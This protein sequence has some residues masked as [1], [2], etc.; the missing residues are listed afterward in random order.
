MPNQL[1]LCQSGDLAVDWSRSQVLS[2]SLQVL[3]RKFTTPVRLD[4]SRGQDIH[5]GI[6]TESNKRY[7]HFKALAS[8]VSGAY[9]VVCNIEEL[10]ECTDVLKPTTKENLKFHVGVLTGS[11]DE[12]SRHRLSGSVIDGALVAPFNAFSSSANT[13][14][15]KH[16]SDNLSTSTNVDIANFTY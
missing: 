11:V 6:N 7:A 16:I 14:V 13:G 3:N 8:R 2:A 15:V 4:V 9:E 5:G 1:A 12:I 10:T